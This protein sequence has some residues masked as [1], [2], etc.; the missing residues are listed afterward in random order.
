MTVLEL[1]IEIPDLADIEVETPDTEVTPSGGAV[2]VVVATPGPPG[3]QGPPGEGFP[4]FG[5]QLT[6]TIDG[7]NMVFTTANGY[8]A[9]T[10]AVFLNGIR[11]TRGIGYGESGASEITFTSAPLVGDDV[12]ID[13]VIS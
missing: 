8:Q 11:E 3:I 6:G 13:Y 2:V 7:V 1:D 9:N 12:R 5:E 10:T 4:V